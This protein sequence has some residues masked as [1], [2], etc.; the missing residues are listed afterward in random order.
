MP[1]VE[2]PAGGGPTNVGAKQI[3]PLLGDGHG[4]YR[5]HMLGNSGSGKTTTGAALAKILDVPLI[6]IDALALD[7]GWVILPRSVF[8][9]RLRAALDAAPNGW[10]VDGKNTYS[11]AEMAFA[12]ATDLIW[13]DPPLYVY[14][15]RVVLRTFLR[16]LHLAPPCSPGC[17]ERPSRVFSRNSILWACL[18]IHWRVRRLNAAHM[19]LFGIENGKS[20]AGRRMRRF[21][22]WGS[23][24]KAWLGEVAAMVRAKK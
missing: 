3:P 17:Y 19:V 11:G 1:P 6:A 21:T 18:S 24:V 9:T 23:D 20:T 4:H 12:E 2:F 16:L 22:G 15:P 8:H 10:V 14:F 13:L 5:I 7:P